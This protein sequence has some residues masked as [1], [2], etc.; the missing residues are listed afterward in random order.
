MGLKNAYTLLHIGAYLW[1]SRHGKMH[2][3]QYL[4][5]QEEINS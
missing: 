4:L 3:Y 1:L 2:L 5:I